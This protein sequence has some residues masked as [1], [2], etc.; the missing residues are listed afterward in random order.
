VMRA[1]TWTIP[2]AALERALDDGRV[3]RVSKDL[4]GAPIN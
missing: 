3:R 4:L 1:L 2:K